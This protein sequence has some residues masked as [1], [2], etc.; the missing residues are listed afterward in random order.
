MESPFGNNSILAP[1][2]VFRTVSL[3][4]ALSEQVAIS[5]TWLGIMRGGMTAQ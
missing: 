5:W 1:T 4:L 2:M 3:R